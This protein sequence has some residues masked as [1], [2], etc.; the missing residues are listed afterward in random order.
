MLFSILNIKEVTAFLHGVVLQGACYPGWGVQMQM[1]MALRSPRELPW[2]RPAG[3]RTRLR[4]RIS[5][6]L[7]KWCS[8]C[9]PSVDD[10]FV[11]ICQVPSVI[12]ILPAVLALILLLSQHFPKPTLGLQPIFLEIPEPT[13]TLHHRTENSL[14]FAN[15]FIICYRM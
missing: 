2:A 13:T 10:R 5:F 6:A 9:P 8:P 7:F 12:Y 11:R 15:K 4:M 1:Q 3:K 14:W